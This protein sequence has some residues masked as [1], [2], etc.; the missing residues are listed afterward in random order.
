VDPGPEHTVVTHILDSDVADIRGLTAGKVYGE[1]ALA[2][3]EE[4]PVDQ[5]EL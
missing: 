3:F 2:A 1:A 5:L 4:R